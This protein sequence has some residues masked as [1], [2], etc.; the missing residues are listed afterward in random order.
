MHGHQGHDG[1]LFPLS[2]IAD[3]MAAST[4]V[5]HIKREGYGHIIHNAFAA[6]RPAITRIKDYEGYTAAPMLADGETCVDIA[7]GR[8]EDNAAKIR[9]YAQPEEHLR[10]CA[11]IRERFKRMVNFDAEEPA[12]REFMERLI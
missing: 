7:D 10:L 11:N 1:F 9:R 6:A 3:A 8:A 4:F 12:I 5:W 2:K